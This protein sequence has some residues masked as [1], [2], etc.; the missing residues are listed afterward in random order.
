M[1]FSCETGQHVTEEQLLLPNILPL[2]PLVLLLVK[3]GDKQ[4]QK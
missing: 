1:R 3:H 4:A 2:A